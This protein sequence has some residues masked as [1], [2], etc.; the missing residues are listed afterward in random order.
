M[1]LNRGGGELGHHHEALKFSSLTFTLERPR[2]Y[3]VLFTRFSI[4]T[5]L[6]V[7]VSLVLRATFSSSSAPYSYGLRFPAVSQKAL[8]TPPTIS[9][10]PINI[11]HIQ[12]CIAGA[13]ETWL[14]RS[15][16]TSLWWSNS[17]RGFVWLDKPVMINKNHSDNRFS[18][19]ARV[20]DK[21]WT[22]FRFSSSRAAVRIARVVLD[23]Y[24]L[25]LPDV[26]WF[27]MGD[28]DTVFFA[29]NLVEA[30]SKYDHEEMWYVGGNS[31]SV[32]QDVMHD[33]DMAFGGGGF[34]ISRPLAARLAAAMDGCLQRYFYFYGSDQRIAACVSE[35][36]VAFT[37]E[38]GFHQLDIRGD[39]YGFLSAHPLAPLVSLH[40]LEYLDPLFPNKT[41]IESL[42][43]LVK[44]Y[45][46]DPHRIL[47]QINCHDHKRQWSISIS[48]GYSIQIYTYFL[49]TKD[50]ET[51]LQ[52][53]KT[54]RSF[55]DGPFTFNTRPLKPDP[56]ERPVTY[57]MD[58]AEDA[59]GSGTKTW[60]SVG[61]KNY[62]HCEKSEHTRV[63]KVK[64]ILVTSM[65]MDPEYWKKAPRRQCCEL[66]EGG[67][68]KEM[69]I[70]IRK[71]SSLEM[72]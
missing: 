26:R 54:W 42:Q 22:R 44:P 3:L 49:T 37:E 33:Y 57:F 36:G 38:R 12:F 48:W 14:D 66:L 34:A 1:K 16:Y 6:I 32:E 19:P 15:R 39:P 28:D 35:I 68:E 53:F 10:G 13:A 72:I 59:R 61:D 62:G 11:S 4:L 63:N 29:E 71:C 7:S 27:V 30:L 50:L 24:R 23:S 5:C 20:S 64:R 2:D 60:Y 55:R 31:E 40:H 51:P 43:T 70:R 17:T 65:K 21:S 45:T 25:N 41:P 18:I 52:T 9:T 58:G 69:S 46:L 67:N 56:C 47:Q 8:A